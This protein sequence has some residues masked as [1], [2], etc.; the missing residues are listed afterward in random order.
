M[1]QIKLQSQL[2]NRYSYYYFED[3]CYLSTPLNNTYK[4]R[5]PTFTDSLIFTDGGQADEVVDWFNVPIFE[6]GILLV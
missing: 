3:I 2:K 1:T 5:Y 4:S 6:A